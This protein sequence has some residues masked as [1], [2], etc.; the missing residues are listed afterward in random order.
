MVERQSAGI[1]VGLGAVEWFD[2][3]L[4]DL[5]G[6]VKEHKEAVK[7]ILQVTSSPHPTYTIA[8]TLTSNSN[9]NRNHAVGFHGVARPGK[10]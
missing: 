6:I 5:D 7:S 3:M 9:P 1:G 2:T 10:R 4:V 8:V